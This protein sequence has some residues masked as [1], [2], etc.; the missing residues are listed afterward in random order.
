VWCTNPIGHACG[1]HEF[2]R[3]SQNIRFAGMT[4]CTH[5]TRRPRQFSPESVHY[6]GKHQN[7]ATHR[8][9]S[10]VAVCLSP[11]PQRRRALSWS[12][13]CVHLRCSRLTAS[14]SGC[15]LRRGSNAVSALARGSAQL[16]SE[17]LT[18]SAACLLLLIRERRSRSVN[19]SR[20]EREGAGI[21]HLR[22][23]TRRDDPQ[24]FAP[25]RRTEA[26]RSI[27]RSLDSG[28]NTVSARPGIAPT[29]R[30]PSKRERRGRE[31]E[32]A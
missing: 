20:G 29:L 17:Q 4:T 15:G 7:R 12:P 28:V 14:A 30:G 23:A 11:S 3:T 19:L 26:A 9:S 21:T 6:V 1:V 27:Y 24:Y 31:R 5:T 16:G 18:T 22:D 8:L 25:L 10:S 32:S 13:P 2:G